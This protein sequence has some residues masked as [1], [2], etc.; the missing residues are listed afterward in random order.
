MM[1]RFCDFCE[2]ED[3]THGN[4]WLF[5]AQCDDG[6]WICDVCWS[7]DQCTSGPNRSKNGPCDDPDCVHRPKMKVRNW[8][9]K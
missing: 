1:Q 2:C 9:K 5:H 4:D 3:C 6:R 7:Y 8:V